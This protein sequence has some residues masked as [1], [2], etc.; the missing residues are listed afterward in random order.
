MNT[1]FDDAV[2]GA[3]ILGLAHA[4]H[5]AKRGRRVIVFERSPLPAGAVGASIR[6]FGM[7]WP[8]GQPAGPMYRLARRSHEIWLEVLGES[9]L[10]SE[11]TGSL[12][13]A[14]NEDEAQVLR[15]FTGAAP[16]AGIDCELIAPS[17]AAK[18]SPAIKIGGLLAAMWSP[19]ETCV[20][21]R[22]VIARLPG[23]LSERY[24]AQFVFG[25]AVTGYDRPRVLAGG[26]EW[27]ADNLYVCAGDD[28]QTLF[29][30]AFAGSGLTRC[31]LQMMRSA[32]M[33]GWRMGPML[34]AGL[35]LTHYQSF[36]DCPSLPALKK[37]FAETMPQYVRYGIHVLVSQTGAGEITIGDSH[38]YG[39]EIEIF[40][41]PEIDRL[42]LDYLD[43]FFSAP[44][45]RIALRWHGV[46]AKHPSEPY[47]VARPAQGVT[48]ITGVGGA[49]M[50]LSFGLAEQV[51]NE[52]W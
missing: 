49:G 18:L 7:I 32:P 45:L 52:I 20:D 50:T 10:W 36:K 39:A 46:Y 25:C 22:K 16:G 26:R 17:R 27:T 13:L 3:G 19:I 44:E 12:H 41:K 5:L 29:P 4:Y 40:D 31:K 15:E 35:T 30:E 11:R 21:P 8:I 42:I 33:N 51:I 28:F 43:T 37:R 34:A 24:G 1:S 9:E 48:A 23:W 47:F 2:V 6:N 38:E 14:Y